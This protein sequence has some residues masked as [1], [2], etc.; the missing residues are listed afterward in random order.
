MCSIWKYCNLLLMLLSC[1]SFL[2]LYSNVDLS[3][4]FLLRGTD[5]NR[6]E[7][8]LR[9]MEKML[10]SRLQGVETTLDKIKKKVGEI[11]THSTWSLSSPTT[12]L[13]P[14]CP[15][16]QHTQ[17][18]TSNSASILTPEATSHTASHY[19]PSATSHL[20]QRTTSN[21]AS[22]LTP[23]ATSHSVI[24]YKPKATS[25]SESHYT[26]S[27]FPHSVRYF[28]PE[29]T[30]HSVSYFTPE[31]TSHS[32]QRTTSHSANILTPEASAHSAS[33]VSQPFTRRMLSSSYIMK[34]QLTG[35]KDVLR[36]YPRP[37]SRSEAGTLAMILAKDAL[38]GEAVMRRCTPLGNGDLPALPEK[39]LRKLKHIM[40][41]VFRESPNEFEITWATCIQSIQHA[42]NRLRYAT[43]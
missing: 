25:H 41:Q 42:S 14:A 43:V 4:N 3:E 29:A 7:T 2:D 13:P 28:T 22:I 8:R 40:E 19:T 37:T 33:P 39:E 21:S 11:L 20:T 18:T 35:V 15:Q 12:M 23:E 27:A 16:I 36:K 38:F 32:T 5:D 10:E 31:A 26:P 17:N 9:R 30:P 6:L 34:S 1:V 24:H